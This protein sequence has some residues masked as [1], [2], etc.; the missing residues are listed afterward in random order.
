MVYVD[1]V[2]LFNFIIDFILLKSLS[3]L[4]KI[5]TKNTRIVLSSLV[6]ELSIVSLFISINNMILFVFK[7]ILS[8]I[9]VLIAFPYIDFKTLIKNTVYFY[10]INFLLGGFLLY[11][12]NE[13]IFKY[14]Y[15]ILLVPFIMKI[16]KFFAYNLKN[17]ISLRYK[18]T[19]Y[20]NNGK[21]LYLNGYM[22][23]ANTL[24]EPYSNKKVIIIN[25]KIDENYFLVPYKTINSKSL[26]K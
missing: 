25:K 20:L 14:K 19:I 5:N 17:K 13:K 15:F 2:I 6:G 26:I 11:F 24:T 23:T 18:V 7:I 3:E 9:M 22:D 1:E 16:C 4:L 12:K 8:L 10:F 21:I